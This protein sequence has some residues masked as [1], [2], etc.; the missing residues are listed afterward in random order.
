MTEPPTEITSLPTNAAAMLMF[1]WN[2]VALP[3]W[4]GVVRTV[5]MVL[6]GL[7]VIVLVLIVAIAIISGVMG[8]IGK[9]RRVK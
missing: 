3:D 7:V 5:M 1:G 6:G 9:L 8:M 2:W 4:F